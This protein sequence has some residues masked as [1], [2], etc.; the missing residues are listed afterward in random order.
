LPQYLEQHLVSALIV[1]TLTLPIL[2]GWP[3][4]R[5]RS[6]DARSR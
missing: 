2:G 3:F 4:G 5:F 6:A 1:V